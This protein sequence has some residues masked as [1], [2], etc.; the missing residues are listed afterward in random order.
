MAENSLKAKK[1]LDG[2]K[3][4][5]SVINA[6]TIKPVNSKEIMKYAEKAKC[7]I[8][9]ECSSVRGGLGTAVGRVL[10]EHGKRYKTIGV[11]ENYYGESDKIGNL[12]RHAGLDAES[13]AEKITDFYRNGN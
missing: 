2:E 9:A 11:E 8:T 3:I 5:A 13:I 7:I 10:G 6:P 12:L 4:Y 1:M